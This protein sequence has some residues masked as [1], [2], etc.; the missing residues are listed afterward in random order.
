MV[1]TLTL[2]DLRAL[3]E[4]LVAV[5]LPGG[6][7]DV[8]VC[9]VLGEIAREALFSHACH[10]SRAESLPEDGQV[11][12]EAWRVFTNATWIGYGKSLGG[13]NGTMAHFYCFLGGALWRWF[14][15]YAPAEMMADARIATLTGLRRLLADEAEQMVMR[16]TSQNDQAQ[17]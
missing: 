5:S 6:N 9:A 10:L 3:D 12:R 1:V 11:A 8:F 15:R 2:E 4:A 13:T 7:D 17:Q 14:G 16:E